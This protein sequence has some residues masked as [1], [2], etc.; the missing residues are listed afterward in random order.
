MIR[1][2]KNKIIKKII[3]LCFMSGYSISG[4][5]YNIAHMMN[6]SGV[7]NNNEMLTW[8]INQGANAIEADLRFELNNPSYFEHGNPCDCT[9]SP[10]AEVCGQII[11]LLDIG[12]LNYF[13][14][15]NLHE[16][17]ESYLNNLAAF[18]GIALFIIDTKTNTLG[19]TDL[20][21]YSASKTLVGLLD[22]NLF[23][24]GYQGNVIIGI[25][26][27]SAINYLQALS[28]IVEGSKYKNRIYF[29]VDEERDVPNIVKELTTLGTVNIC[30]GTGITTVAPINFFSEIQQASVFEVN[31]EIAFTYAWTVDKPSTMK[32][33][34]ES[35]ARGIMTN[36]PQVLATVYQQLGLTL[37]KPGDPL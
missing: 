14:S 5:Y 12:Y 15:C 30:Y 27:V 13:K 17:I 1:F 19:T 33:Y 35:G 28:G 29:S 11:G 37:A 18:P 36:N 24:N 3:F 10:L 20:E 23:S 25:A 7:S 26:K 8:A 31:H 21:I 22:D 32:T 9:F 34:V 4:N 16:S 6:A 2:C